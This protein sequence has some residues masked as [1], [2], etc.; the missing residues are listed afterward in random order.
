MRKG[1]FLGAVIAI[2]L[3]AAGM[4]TAQGTVKIGYL[5][6]LTGDWAAYGQTEVK[7]A[8]LAVEEINAKGGVV[9]SQIQLVPYDFRTRAEDAVNAVRRMIEQDKVYAI[10]GANGSGI[11]IATAPVVNRAGVS[12]IGTV[13]TNPIVTV[14]N[15]GK[16]RPYSFRICFTDPYQGKVL[17]YF[18]ASE[19]GK[20][21]A[22]ILYDVGNEYSQGL[23]QFF[24]ENFEAYGG[25][26]VSDLGFRGAVDVDFRA[27]LTEIRNSGADV[28][29]LPNMGKE[30]A[31]IIKQ[32]RE[33]GMA[34]L[35]IIGGDGYADFMWEIAGD[36]MEGTYWVNHV[37][38]EDPAMQPFFEAYLK[39]Y[40]DECKEF[41]NGVLAYESVYWLA[42]AIN[43]AGKIDRKAIRDALEDTKNL[44]L[45][46]AVL[47]IDPADHNPKDKDAVILE[48]KDGKS[49]FFMKVKPD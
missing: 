34:D 32:A 3:L 44:Q 35:L 39:K 45:H 8:Q 29:V 49:R 30:M 24:I 6:A 7:A 48:C 33:L 47:T 41:V 36:A 43:R 10:I 38:P 22:A 42:D 14:D 46:H 31:L 1:L 13:S 5:A 21:K 16:V 28:L 23:R 40:N 25:K 26:I 19:M 9:G 17:A 2:V 4:A 20:G 27:Q 18:A 11:N 37:A 12:Q 15:D